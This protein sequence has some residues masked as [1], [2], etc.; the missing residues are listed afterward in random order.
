MSLEPA[1]P[2]FPRPLVVTIGAMKA[3][4][5]S[6]HAWMDLHPEVSMSLRKE[7]NFFTQPKPPPGGMLTYRMMLAGR[8]R[9]VGESSVNYTK[10][11]LFGGVPERMH[12]SVPRARLIYVLRDPIARALS[13]YRHNL[14]HGR[15]RRGVREAFA[16]LPNNHYA[17]TSRYF[18]QSE[19]FL[20]HY[21]RDQLLYIDFAQLRDDPESA[22]ETVFRF[23]GVDPSFR[24]PGFGEVHHDSAEKGKPNKLGA[25]IST[26]PILRH[27]RYAFPGVF[28]E[29]LKRPELPADVRDA[30]A[31]HLGPD[32]AAIREL[33]G[34]RLEG[35]AV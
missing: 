11:T 17:A 28:E 23:I 22:M 4:T 21:D 35:W 15:E 2:R 20:R 27:V 5:S 25:P 32:V 16:D 18:E 31:E 30:L 7:L 6:L 19:R 12:A 13:H 29:P 3:G 14:S 24:H 9:V 10:H 8:G 1:G 34:L 26:I 33:S